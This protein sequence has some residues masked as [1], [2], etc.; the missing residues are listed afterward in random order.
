MN[1]LLSTDAIVAQLQLE[2]E[3]L[4]KNYRQLVWERSAIL[5]HPQ[6]DKNWPEIFVL[7]PFTPKLI[8]VYE[9]HIKKALAVRGGTS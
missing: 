4:K 9:D 5:G 8:P 6:E 2:T 3:E 1:G 7:M